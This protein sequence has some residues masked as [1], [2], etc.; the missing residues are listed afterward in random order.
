MHKP[1]IA[2][3]HPR[4]F[5]L[6]ESL[7]SANLS[8]MGRAISSLLLLLLG[9][10]ADAAH[11]NDVPPYL[12]AALQLDGA[13]VVQ[14]SSHLNSLG[15]RA[16]FL[17]VQI[18][19]TGNKRGYV[20]SGDDAYSNGYVMGSVA[21]DH[22]ELLCTTYIEHIVIS[23]LS[24]TLD[25]W[26]QNSSFAPV[27]DVLLEA[28]TDLLVSDAVKS[29]NA[30]VKANAILPTLV[31]EMRGLVDGVR[32]VN[33]STLVTLDKISTLNFG[34]DFLLGLIYTGQI[35]SLLGEKVGV[36][37]TS[38]RLA[39]I[40]RSHDSLAGVSTG[41]VLR[42]MAHLPPNLTIK[43]IVFCDF[44]AASGAATPGGNG[45]VF[46]SDLACF[47]STDSFYYLFVLSMTLTCSLRAGSRLSIPHRRG[48]P[49]V[50][51]HN[52][53]PARQRLVLAEP[54]IRVRV[55]AR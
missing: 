25:E 31:D 53:V 36:W 30:S 35:L 5:C 9:A 4:T 27:Y 21:A 1:H 15:I 29:F 22:V 8:Q 14:S 26:L 45:S 43:P 12:T 46:V 38:G 47:C 19:G 16:K 23:L 37:A 50:A 6:F 44:F 41:D 13:V 34:Y 7:Y 24:E 2:L 3:N 32:S 17:D 33:A 39:E 52:C 42:S 10:H 20:I 28:L 18:N 54:A 55:Y 11:L 48:V 40:L 49:G 51:V